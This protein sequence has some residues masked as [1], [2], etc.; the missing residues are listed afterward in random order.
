MRFKEWCLMQEIQHYFFDDVKSVNGFK[1]DGIDFRFED[2]GRGYNPEVPRNNIR[3][4]PGR[5]DQFFSGSFSA[6]MKEGWLNVDVG[7]GGAGGGGGGGPALSMMM[8]GQ[9]KISVDPEATQRPLPRHWF[10]FAAIY[11]GN[12]IVKPPE[13]PRDDYERKAF[14]RFHGTKKVADVE[15]PVM[16]HEKGM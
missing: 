11:D 8:M 2:W 4:N 16:N 6:P 9:K 1:C 13:W 12:D 14:D 3:P 7:G 5:G 10:D 15:P